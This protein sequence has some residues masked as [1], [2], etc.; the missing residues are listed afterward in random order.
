MAH[1]KKQRR[2]DRPP[3]IFAVADQAYRSLIAS[4][5]NQSILIT[6]ES[7]AGKTEN[8]K[9]VIQYLTAIT[10]GAQG[11][12]SL[13][14][15]QIVRANPIL[16]AFGNAQTVRNHNSSRFGKFIK[17]EFNNAGTI[18][19]GNIERY[20]LEK[21]RVTHRDP[22]E[23]SFH[24]FYQL[25]AGASPD[26]KAGLG[27]A[28]V[29]AD[30]DYLKRSNCTVEGINDR[31]EFEHLVECMRILGLTEEEQRALFSIVAAILHL[32]NVELRE[33]AEGQAHFGNPAVVEQVCSV[34]GVPVEE[35]SRTLLNPVIKAGRDEVVSQ[36]RDVAQVTY[37]VE[38][39]SR[40]LYDR[41]FARL[42]E[43]IN[44]AID[45]P[46]VH[47][48]GN[49]IGVLDIA[50]FEIFEKNS[51]EQLCINHTNERLQQFFNHHMFVSEQEE[52]RKDGIEWEYI[53]FG[54]DLQPTID[55]IERSS[56]IGV[57]AC[58]DEDCVMPK[59][60]DRGFLE[61]LASL[62]GKNRSDKFETTR[63]GDGFVLHHYAG[64]V[65]YETEGW[66]VK[67]KD[68]L[69]E[70]VTRLLASQ[71]HHPFIRELFPDYAGSDEQVYQ[72]SR[73]SKRGLFRTVAQKHRE[74]LNLL[75]HELNSTQPHF[76]RCI[77][78]NEC[79]QAGLIDASLV[80]NQL[81]CNGVLEGIRICRLGYPNRMA[82]GEFRHLYEILYAGQD[83]LR[84]EGGD[85]GN[86]A[87]CV[88]ILAS[89]GLEEGAAFRLGHTKVF[90]RAGEVAKL[91]EM[92]DRRVSLA[93]R[94]FQ[95]IY[96]LVLAK[97]QRYRQ[98]HLKEATQFLQKNIRLYL[99]LRQ[100]SWWKLFSTVKPLL[101]VTR[102]EKRIEELEGELSRLSLERGVQVEQLRGELDRERDMLF[103]ME[104]RRRDLERENQQL[105]LLLGE[106]EEV[107]TTLMEQ[108]TRQ[109][110]QI[111]QLK[112]RM[113]AELAGQRSQYEDRLAAL[114]GERTSLQQA[115]EEQRRL[116]TEL[117]GQL[118]ALDFERIKL[119]RG[120]MA[121]KQRLAE[122]ETTLEEL[123]CGKRE[124]E[125]RI[126]QL[127]EARRQ[128]QEQL[129]EEA[130][131]QA[132][133]RQAQSEFEA[134]LR[135]IRQQHEEELRG[136][137]EEWE[138][139]R[140]RL[141]REIHQLTF[142]LEQEK[143]T[144]ASLR[145][146][147]KKYETGA[148]SLTTKLEA[149]LRQQSAWKRERERLE[150]RLREISRLHGEAIEREDSLQAQLSG[151][152]EQMR[153]LRA[154]LGDLEEALAAS[155][156]QRKVLEG[157]YESL[158]EHHREL[159]ATKQAV[160]R[161]CASL[162]L[163]AGE[164]GS[165]LHE[166]QDASLVL[167]ERT[168]TLETMLKVTQ[169]E[170]EG[171]RRQAERLGQEKIVLEMQ[172]KELQMKLLDLETA[173]PGG[174]ASRAPI[175]RATTVSYTQ[176]LAQLEADS[177]ERQTMLK[178]TRKLE[179][180]VR[181]LGSQLAERDRER[182]GLEESLEKA[183]LR[184]RKTQTALETAES[185]LA[186]LETIRRRIE[187]DHQ[188]ERDRADRLARECERLKA[189]SLAMRASGEL[190]RA[191]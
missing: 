55:L 16:E 83:N 171:E 115:M 59:A 22:K 100:W 61:K 168:G 121:A 138:A 126:R 73:G 113:E 60:T 75:M 186:E 36:A 24:I 141:Q 48:R 79:K 149:E 94:S 49:F 164:L 89:L 1:Y 144:G 20:L 135:L 178:E 54:L 101:N 96:R 74:S 84:M 63:F 85:A 179:R 66:L 117:R 7:G 4:R 108:K 33:D 9:R 150:Q 19:G 62:W 155:E 163:Q 38:A 137:E 187:R 176:L 184:L 15:E 72:A 129:E 98:S 170:L 37:S 140:K 165:Q 124:A 56:P 18:A 172:I 76:V 145:D 180:T 107:K 120:E 31:A 67:N 118:D 167:K 104:T 91:D 87:A 47:G 122:A 191:E 152:Y 29:P 128:L 160:E 97:R 157:R 39:L 185:R 159:T 112:E 44:R 181:E 102:A 5:R 103:D 93:L 142:D 99:R 133:Y 12:S 90:L 182:I 175:R 27:I 28:G 177:T 57:L 125:G 151:Q 123:R 131:D 40:A 34:L 139:G 95:A 106:A 50:G 25:L 2:I 32:G 154:R 183:D 130:A 105:S 119:E 35:F 30:F 3:H 77:V 53:D 14:E 189:R 92:R 64:R 190:V 86:R 111:A 174:M 162:E 156:R 134:Q 26:L 147:V 153:E 116:V 110:L 169:G 46:S 166:E 82:F 70:N 78:P 43:R 146:T 114:E 109:D 136:A 65:E 132:K 17:I 45:R 41:M 23:R 127:E 81:R 68:P 88:A 161:Q 13:L 42:V 173:A 143:K 51:F 80:L 6:G 10:L 58:L 148:D 158:S 8:T 52:Y 21:S 71:S 69:N 188:E 11:G